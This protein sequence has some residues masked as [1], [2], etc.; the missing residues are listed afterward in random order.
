MSSRTRISRFL[1]VAGALTLAACGDDDAPATD[2]G[3]AGLD[4][5][6]ASGDTTSGDTTS[7]DAATDA[8]V[9]PDD[10]SSTPPDA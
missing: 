7:P 10:G 2:N 1:L 5:S 3:D 9:Q 8:D 6:E 4:T